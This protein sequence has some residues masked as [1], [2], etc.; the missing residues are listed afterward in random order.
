MKS[1]SQRS[2]FI[3]AA[4]RPS[5]S[6]FASHSSPTALKLLAAA[7]VAAIRSSLICSAGSPS[8]ASTLRAASRSARFGE[9]R[10][11]PYAEGQCLL[12]AEMAIIH[13]PVA[14]SRRRHQ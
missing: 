12:L 14:P 6:A 9:P 4:E 13:P 5:R 7:T 2:F 10:V 8:L 1:S 11:G 3:V